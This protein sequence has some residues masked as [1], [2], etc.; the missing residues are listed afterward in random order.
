MS[1]AT[2][3]DFQISGAN[4]LHRTWFALLRHTSMNAAFQIDCPQLRR[5]GTSHAGK[6]PSVATSALMT[7]TRVRKSNT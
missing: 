4:N 1:V 6:R 5:I 7:S 3:I 2:A